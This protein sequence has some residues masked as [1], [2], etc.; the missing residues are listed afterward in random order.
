MRLPGEQLVLDTNVLV[1]LLRKKGPAGALLEQEYAIGTRRPR[2][3]V[4]V[5]VKGELKS[6][7]FQFGWGPEQQLGLDSLL[8]QLPTVD[9]SSSLVIGAYAK[10]DHLSR[11]SGRSMGKNDVWLAAVAHV[12]SAVLLTTD[13]DFDHLSPA[14][15]RVEYIDPE[16]LKK[17]II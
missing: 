4:P 1:H 13:K 11:Q 5:V 16:K 9:I 10:L 14:H 17:G 6:L 15:L 3:L 7:A 12:Q 8:A 2:V